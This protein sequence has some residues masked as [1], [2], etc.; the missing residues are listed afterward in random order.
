MLLT[1]LV[2]YTK[3]IGVFF[4][5]YYIFLPINTFYISVV[6]NLHNILRCHVE[7]INC[8]RFQA[9]IAVNRQ[10]PVFRD[11]KINAESSFKMLVP[12]YQIT[13]CHVTEYG[14]P[15]IINF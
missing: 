5:S 10:M 2:K 13:Q 15:Q 7:G 11:V 6:L 9:L 8:V 12:F 1:D 14:S 4:F 3:F